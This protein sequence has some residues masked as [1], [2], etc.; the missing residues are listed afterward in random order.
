MESSSSQNLQP[1]LYHALMVLGLLM[2]QPHIS[3][4]LQKRCICFLHNMKT[5]QDEIVLTC[6]RN[7]VR[8]ANTPIGHTIAFLRI[9]LGIDI[10]NNEIMP[11]INLSRV[12]FTNEQRMLLS[13]LKLLI[14]VRNGDFTLPYLSS[15][16]IECLITIIA[17]L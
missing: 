3:Y 14:A 16:E 8:N 5:S 11:D 12:Y 1:A 7:A 10:D 4:Q 6:Y 2:N 15:S 17:T 9:T 13:N